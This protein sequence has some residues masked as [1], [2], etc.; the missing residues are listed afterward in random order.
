MGYD[1]TY[2]EVKGGLRTPG[3]A[4]RQDRHD[5]PPPHQAFELMGRKP[6]IASVQVYD[7]GEVDCVLVADHAGGKESGRAQDHCQAI[8]VRLVHESFDTLL[9]LGERV[10]GNRLLVISS[11]EI[12]PREQRD[13]V[14]QSATPELRDKRHTQHV[15]VSRVIEV[16]VDI[17]KPLHVWPEIGSGKNR[18]SLFDF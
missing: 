12:A 10:F 14:F 2:V 8:K 1:L 11:L 9:Q 4:P 5:I 15:G 3:I 16:V 13:Q 17:L 18:I 7:K 6:V